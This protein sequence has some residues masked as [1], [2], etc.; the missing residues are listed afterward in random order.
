MPWTPR[1]GREEVAD[2]IARAGSWHDVLD[3]LGYAYH[4]KNIETMRKW[5]RRW[6]IAIDHLSDGRGS[7]RTRY[8]DAGLS[9]RQCAA[10]EVLG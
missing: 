5:S 7:A 4:G 6:G 9:N 10:S 2:A 3:A 1:V 8:T